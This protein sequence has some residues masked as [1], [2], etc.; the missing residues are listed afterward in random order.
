MKLSQKR[1]CNGCK[2]GWNDTHPLKH[3]CTLGFEVKNGDFEGIPLEPCYK[4][5]TNDKYI[6]V[7]DEIYDKR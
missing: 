5:L 7:S 4:P 1:N 6:K 2:A 3:Y